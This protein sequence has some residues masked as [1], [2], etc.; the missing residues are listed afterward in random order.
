MNVQVVVAFSQCISREKV[1]TGGKKS[2][3]YGSSLTD[4]TAVQYTLRPSKCP[5][6]L[7]M[8]E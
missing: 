1:K 8:I 5:C 6:L 3:K 7:A 2:M 4:W